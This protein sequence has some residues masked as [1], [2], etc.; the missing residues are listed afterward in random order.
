MQNCIGDMHERKYKQKLGIGKFN[1][2][3]HI[4]YV[5]WLTERE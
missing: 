3:E 5:F 2:N 4:F 1:L